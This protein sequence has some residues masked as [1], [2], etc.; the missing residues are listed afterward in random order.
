MVGLLVFLCFNPRG[1]TPNGPVFET[2]DELNEA[3]IK[4][5]P[6]FEKFRK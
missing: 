1:Y 6:D 5:D 2:E 3:L 4:V